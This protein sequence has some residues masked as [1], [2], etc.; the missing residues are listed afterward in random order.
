MDVTECS[1]V[2]RVA[3][4][5]VDFIII[6]FFAHFK[7]HIFCLQLFYEISDQSRICSNFYFPF[8]A[9]GLGELGVVQNII[10]DS[11]GE[12]LLVKILELH[13]VRIA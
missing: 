5:L 8:V 1:I 9:L 6:A 13:D 7:N 2:I 3:D 10:E 11:D 12:D 4:D